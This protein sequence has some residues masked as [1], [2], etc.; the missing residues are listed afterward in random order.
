MQLLHVKDQISQ[1][2]PIKKYGVLKITSPSKLLELNSKEWLIL[3]KVKF[4][5]G[6]EAV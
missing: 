2:W 6:N 3:I 5:N 1:V 4:L